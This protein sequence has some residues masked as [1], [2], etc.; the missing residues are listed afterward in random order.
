MSMPEGTDYADIHAVLAA[1]WRWGDLGRQ[2]VRRFLGRWLDNL[3]LTGPDAELR[4][5]LL[6]QLARQGWQLRSDDSMLVIADP[7][8]ASRSV[9]RSCA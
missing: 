7:V 1:V 4:G 8:R 9:L 3:M 5:S 2:A 6:E